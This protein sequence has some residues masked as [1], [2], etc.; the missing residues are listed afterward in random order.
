R[1]DAI[2]GTLEV[3]LSPTEL[4][5]RPLAK[6][7]FSQNEFGVGRELFAHMRQMV[8]A[9]EEGATVFRFEDFEG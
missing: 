6:G 2:A 8:S 4:A 9:P 1:L 7:D 3:K 5:A